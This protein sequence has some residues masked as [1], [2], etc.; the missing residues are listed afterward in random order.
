MKSEIELLA[1]QLAEL[2]AGQQAMHE[3][4]LAI[5][6]ESLDRSGQLKAIVQSKYAELY[7]RYRQAYTNEI[8]DR[9]RE[10]GE[11]RTSEFIN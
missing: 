9:F 1:M 3:I 4:Y 10:A 8:A 11:D 6:E 5:F 2:R 7:G